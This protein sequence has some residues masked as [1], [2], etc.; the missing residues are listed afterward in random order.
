VPEPLTSTR[1][2]RLRAARGRRFSSARAAAIALGLPVSTYGAHERAESPGGR[3]YSPEDAQQYARLFGV[4]AEWLLTGYAALA[5]ETGGSAPPT[6]QAP[7]KVRICGYVGEGIRVHFYDVAPVDLEQIKVPMLVSEKTAALEIR[8]KSLGS[9]FNR[10]YVL[11]DDMR[12][13]P[14]PN[15][16]GGLY[17]VGLPGERVFIKQLHK[18]LAEGHLDFVSM[19]GSITRNA[20]ILWVGRIRALLQL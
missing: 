7:S 12:E 1:G 18:G 2:E 10:W 14:M 5:S 3:D 6:V 16:A 20:D 9:F 8:S 19:D 15:L 4:T 11:F 17:V 13:R